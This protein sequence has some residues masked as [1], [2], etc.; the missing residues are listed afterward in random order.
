MRRAAAINEAREYL[1]EALANIE[2][3]KT[4]LAE[5]AK[6]L[7]VAPARISVGGK[8]S[9][10][11]E[12]L[13]KA[14]TVDRGSWE[15][16]R[17]IKTDYKRQK[18]PI[19]FELAKMDTTRRN[20]PPWPDRDNTRARDAALIIAVWMLQKRGI[21]PTRGN[22][23]PPKSG[24]DEVAKIAT[25]LGFPISWSRLQK[26][27]SPVNDNEFEYTIEFHTKSWLELGLIDPFKKQS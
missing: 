20:A 18:L 13:A 19:P 3:T 15:A 26:I 21:T 4:A 11:L 10:R 22:D 1:K 12:E 27:W 23:S 7:A 5:S 14:A 8:P 9:N 6:F 17:A 2:G 16:A 24:C 25:E